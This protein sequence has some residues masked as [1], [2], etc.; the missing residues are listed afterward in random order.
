MVKKYNVRMFVIRQ[1]SLTGQDIADILI[2][3]IENIYIFLKKHNPP[4][5]ASITKSGTIS[6]IR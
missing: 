4:F 1:A 2:K 5:I 6:K 3:S